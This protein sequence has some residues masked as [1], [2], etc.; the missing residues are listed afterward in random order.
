[1]V[2]HNG[3]KRQRQQRQYRVKVH[4]EEIAYRIQVCEI[5][6]AVEG[7]SQG[8]MV[9][10]QVEQGHCASSDPQIAPWSD[11]EYIQNAQ[12]PRCLDQAPFAC[13]PSLS[14]K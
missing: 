13:H 7:F 14:P 3:I 4:V 2:V 12:Q 8:C 9:N 10:H 1:M 11:E 5:K 6:V